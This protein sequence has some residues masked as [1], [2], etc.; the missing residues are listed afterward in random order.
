MNCPVLSYALMRYPDNN[1]EQHTIQKSATTRLCNPKSPWG[2]QTAL[3]LM[4]HYALRSIN[5]NNNNNNQQHFYKF[6][7]IFS[8]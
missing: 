8:K 6:M 3:S 1:G 7:Y 5:R 2:G 4:A